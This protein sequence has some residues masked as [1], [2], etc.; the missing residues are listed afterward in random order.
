MS[1][2]AKTRIAL[3]ADHLSL[4]RRPTAG[5]GRDSGLSTPTCA[6][7]LRM[8][9]FTGSPIPTRTTTLG[10]L[11]G[12]PARGAQTSPGDVRQHGGGEQSD[13][14]HADESRR[15]GRAGEMT[16][17]CAGI[18]P[19]DLAVSRTCRRPGRPDP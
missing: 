4:P 8:A 11:P 2:T 17:P 10:P 3:A 6:S 7:A 15:L 19:T 16:R 18:R 13:G 9:I 14:D 12:R 1:P 5:E